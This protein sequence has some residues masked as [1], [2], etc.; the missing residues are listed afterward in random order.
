[1]EKG[2]L[3]AVSREAYRM[4]LEGKIDQALSRYI[5]LAAQGFEIANYNAAFILERSDPPKHTQRSLFFYSRAALLDNAYARKKIADA[6]FKAGD[7]VA[8]ASYYYSA[9]KSVPPS[10]EALFNLAYLFEHGIGLKRDLYSAIDMYNAALL[11]E[12][13]AYIAVRLSV[14]RC[15]LKLFLKSFSNIFRTEPAVNSTKAK[16]SG[17]PS[18]KDKLWTMFWTLILTCFI[19]WYMNYYQNR[20]V[21]QAPPPPPAPQ[22]DSPTMAMSDSSPEIGANNNENDSEKE[23]EKD[24]VD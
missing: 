18:D 12:K 10:A 6:F 8:A 2:E 14:S 3:L 11:S 15:R 4:Y 5:Y 9:A 20:P 22:P 24:S 13:S 21:A 19:Y 23:S 16:P 7:L 17:L 1:M